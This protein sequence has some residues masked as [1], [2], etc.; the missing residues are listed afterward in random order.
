M[1]ALKFRIELTDEE[2]VIK[3]EVKKHEIIL[4]Y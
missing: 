4:D 3:H 2:G 1:K